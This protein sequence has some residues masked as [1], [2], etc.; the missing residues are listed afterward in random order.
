LHGGIHPSLFCIALGNDL[1][2]LTPCPSPLAK[3]APEEGSSLIYS[4]KD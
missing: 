1:H 2:A 3:S 4:E